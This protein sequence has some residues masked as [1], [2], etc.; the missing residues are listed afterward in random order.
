MWWGVGAKGQS[1]AG[2]EG[3]PKCLWQFGLVW[4]FYIHLLF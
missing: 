1:D 2:A 3:T 4:P